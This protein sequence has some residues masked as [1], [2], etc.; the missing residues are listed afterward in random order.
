MA[1]RKYPGYGKAVGAG[2]GVVLLD[3][4]PYVGTT[5]SAKVTT[6]T[7]KREDVWDVGIKIADGAEQQDGSSPIGK[8]VHHFL[9]IPLDGNEHFGDKVGE[10]RVDMLKNLALACGAESKGDA[11]PDPEDLLE[12]D[13]SFYAK[14]NTY[15]SKSGEQKKNNQFSSFKAYKE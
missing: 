2:G 8:T 4:G 11:V 12:K 14:V 6:D 5:V 1:V 13:V 3:E 15:E 9:R 10:I 7:D